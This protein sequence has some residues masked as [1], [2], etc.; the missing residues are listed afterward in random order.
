MFKNK[1]HLKILVIWQ[2]QVFN[3]FCFIFIFLVVYSLFPKPS[4]ML[5]FVKNSNVFNFIYIPITKKNKTASLIF[6]HD[7]YIDIEKRS[8]R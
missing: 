2:I 7:K 8:K 5:L 3:F 4:S 1:E 6:Y